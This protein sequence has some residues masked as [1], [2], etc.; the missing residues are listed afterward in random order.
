MNAE[1][2]VKRP[3]SRA[4]VTINRAQALEEDDRLLFPLDLS[5]WMPTERILEI[6]T[7]LIEE[8]NWHNPEL[9]KYLRAH[10]K[11][12]PKMLLR[13]LCFAYTTGTVAAEE[14]E[15]NCFTDP[16]LRCICENDPPESKEI[17]RFRRNNRGLLKWVLAQLLKEV[18]RQKFALREKV[19]PAG[20]RQ[21]LF[22]AAVERLDLARHLDGV[23]DEI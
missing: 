16:F 19:F 10:P 21:F 7:A 6:I 14:I 5:E 3:R 1:L 8:L 13:L 18:L 20:L 15:S 22:E 12:R 4:P 2:T 11:Y 17:S 23:G 9:V